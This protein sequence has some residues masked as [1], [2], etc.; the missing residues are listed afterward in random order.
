LATQYPAG[1]EGG[2]SRDFSITETIE[3]IEW[4]TAVGETKFGRARQREITERKSFTGEIGATLTNLEAAS[5]ASVV[6]DSGSWDVTEEVVRHEASTGSDVFTGDIKRP[7]VL[8]NA[9]YIRWQKIAG[10]FALRYNAI[11]DG[12]DIHADFQVNGADPYISAAASHVLTSAASTPKVTVTIPIGARIAQI[13]ERQTI[14]GFVVSEYEFE[15]ITAND[16]ATL[17]NHITEL[18]DTDLAFDG[19][20]VA[21]FSNVAMTHNDGTIYEVSQSFSVSGDGSDEATGDQTVTV[22]DPTTYY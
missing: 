15:F 7:F 18:D 20:T 10:R 11:S 9:L 6:V 14:D 8:V 12:A 4:T 19:P 3:P 2:V 13:S 1:I 17:S 5:D 16:V 21:N 22:Y